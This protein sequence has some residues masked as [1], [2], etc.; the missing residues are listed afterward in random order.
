VSSWLQREAAEEG[1][2][3][4]QAWSL[5]RRDMGALIGGTVVAGIVCSVV[6]G[7]GVSIIVASLGTSSA[8][9]AAHRVLFELAAI[10]LLF[11][12][13]P[14][15]GGLIA[16]VTKHVRSGSKGRVGDIFEG[17]GQFVPLVLAAVVI[18]GPA[19]VVAAL[20]GRFSPLTTA[21]YSLV[22]AVIALPFV[23]LLPVIVDRRL[24]I[25]QALS[26]SLRLLRRGGLGRTLV[27]LVSLILIETFMDVPNVLGSG[28]DILGL[29]IE[30]VV[31]PALLVYIV[32]MYFRAAGEQDSLDEAIAR[33]DP[34]RVAEKPLSVPQVGSTL[35]PSRRGG[36]GP[37]KM[38]KR[39]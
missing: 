7:I 2:L 4:R 21:L 8:G 25:R 12:L 38:P 32:C 5:Y 36:P 23:Y 28:W 20:V 26:C 11:V 18:L 22:E 3:I 6:A 19:M 39:L 9:L 24:G 16:M 17:F 13:T 29:A 10:A 1:R 37:L 34:P 30:V 14:F 35:P 31:A 33:A 27:A 15:V